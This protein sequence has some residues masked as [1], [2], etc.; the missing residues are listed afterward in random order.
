MSEMTP[1]ALVPRPGGN[2]SS[3]PALPPKGTIR[4]KKDSKV[5]KGEKFRIGPSVESS[6]VS[7]QKER[8]GSAALKERIKV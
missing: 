5:A 6:P 8:S 2:D 1:P 4:P 7:T 3:T